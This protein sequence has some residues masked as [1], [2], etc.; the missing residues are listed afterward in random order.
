[1]F[2]P[3]ESQ[4]WGN[5]VGAVSGVAQSQTRLKQLSSSSSKHK[6]QVFLLYK[7]IQERSVWLLSVLKEE[8]KTNEGLLVSIFL[9]FNASLH[10]QSEKDLLKL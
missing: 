7:I 5:L 4:G 3:G 1:M 10:L 9:L 6:I 2:L 8:I